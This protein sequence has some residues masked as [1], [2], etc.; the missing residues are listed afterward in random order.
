MAEAATV[1]AQVDMSTAE[2][3]PAL[4]GADSVTVQM[5]RTVPDASAT[6]AQDQT[7]A[8]QT[9]DAPTTEPGSKDAEIADLTERLSKS[10]QARKTIEGRNKPW[11]AMDERMTTF[12]TKLDTVSSTTSESAELISAFAEASSAD[13]LDALPAEVN[14]IRA[15][16]QRRVEITQT[17][18]NSRDAMDAM[19]RGAERF[20]WDIHTAPEL[21]ES[22]EAWNQAKAIIDSE[23]PDLG[24]AN[25]WITRATSLASNTFLDASL[26]SQTQATQTADQQV[27]NATAQAQQAQEAA[28]QRI[29]ESGIHDLGTPPPA[30]SSGVQSFETL[31]AKPW[32]ELKQMNPAQLEQYK[33]DIEAARKREGRP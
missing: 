33:A 23:N 1:P 2:E 13:T 18:Q 9:A 15:N 26:N 3:V 10:E 28:T 30:G 25:G 21:A 27:A 20:G 32:S 7:P 12:E 31:M 16:G 11:E 5:A 4:P 17:E 24:R 6:P 19:T 14:K 22:R 29:N 8:A